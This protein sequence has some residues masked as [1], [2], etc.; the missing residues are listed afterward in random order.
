MCTP[1]IEMLDCVAD[2]RSLRHSRHHD[3]CLER[4]A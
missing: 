4:R 3:Q 1:T 2:A